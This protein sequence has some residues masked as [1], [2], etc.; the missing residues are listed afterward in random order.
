MRIHEQRC[1]AKAT[2]LGDGV[3]NFVNIVERVPEYS[4]LAD[5]TAMMVG[6]AGHFSVTDPRDPFFPP[7]NELLRRVVAD[8]FPMFASCF[9]FQLIVAAL[10]GEVIHD[11]DAT[12][13]GSFDLQLTEE[14]RQ[15]SL[16]S[17]LPDEFI[18]QMGHMDR[19]A[20]MPPGVLN[21]AS[22]ELSPLQALRIPGRPI[23]ASQFHP[24]LD[25][26]TN[27]E[28]YRAYIDRYGS[29]DDESDGNSFVSLPSPETSTLLPA[30]L[31]MITRAE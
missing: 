16:F 14:G 27:Y 21:L 26:Q 22:S 31:D 9:G 24:E 12:E 20:N 5:C 25:Q 23:W 13:V 17:Q 6:G 2:G 10:G 8:G 18:G 7:T 1:F 30:F 15:D 11:A 3:L 19:A 29:H 4:E 28:R